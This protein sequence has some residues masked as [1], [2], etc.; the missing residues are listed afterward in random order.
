MRN[1]TATGRLLCGPGEDDV[2][3]T[4]DFFLLDQAVLIAGPRHLLLWH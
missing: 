1:F 3:E 4:L 2:E